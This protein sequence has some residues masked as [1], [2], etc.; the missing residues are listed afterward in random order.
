[1][2]MQTR[3][4]AQPRGA[5]PNYQHPDVQIRIGRRPVI[6]SRGSRHLQSRASSRAR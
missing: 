3:R 4:G 2:L 5:R 1:M 6:Q